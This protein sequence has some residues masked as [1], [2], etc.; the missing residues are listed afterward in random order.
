V[1]LQDP[2][3]ALERLGIA[4]VLA[5]L[6]FK[7]GLADFAPNGRRK[8]P[9]V[10]LARTHENSGFDG[11]ELIIHGIMVI[12]LY[13]PVKDSDDIGVTFRTRSIDEINPCVGDSS[14]EKRASMRLQ[15]DRGAL[16]TLNGRNSEAT[17]QNNVSVL[18]EVA[19][20]L[21]Q[22]RDERN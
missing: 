15:N 13:F 20:A 21:A 19:Q 11:A 5:E 12:Y 3:K 18:P 9:E 4:W 14:A 8:G 1:N 22:A 10:L 17:S 7:K 2:G 6:R 16:A